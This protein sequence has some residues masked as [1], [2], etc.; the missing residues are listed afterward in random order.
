[1]EIAAV[2]RQREEQQR[3]T[4][5]A[6]IEAQEKHRTVVR[7]R[8]T[9]KTE[10]EQQPKK[11]ENASEDAAAKSKRKVEKLRKRLEKEEKRIAKAE[12]KAYKDDVESSTKK[13]KR[14]RSDSGG[15][16]N[17]EIEDTDLAK[18]K[19]EDTASIVP[20]PL[21]PISQPA[22]TDEERNPSS[23]DLIADDTPGQGNCATGQ[24]GDGPS[25]SD[26]DRLIQNSSDP[27]HDSS[28]DSSSTDSQELTSSSG[29]SS[30]DESH[31]EAPD[32]ISTKRNGG[33]RLAPPKRAKP[34]QICREFL[35]KGLCKRGSHC[36]YLHDLPERGSRRMRTQD[37][38][39]GER[40][41]ERL[42]LYQRVSYSAQ[43]N[44][45]AKT[46]VLTMCSC[47]F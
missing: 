25:F 19:L 13:K 42:G 38:K 33:D 7:E 22:P 32:E 41:K 4:N 2:K 35:N 46:S 27:L 34:K 26:I 36:K 16:G 3:A 21:T 45:L 11:G 24:E 23:K 29:S 14:K 17:R 43:R 12:T 15:S 5:Q 9:Q 18:P 28:S 40:R 20:D 8:Q 10:R 31:N 39:G 30:D 44:I 6:R 47:S 1:M 37:N